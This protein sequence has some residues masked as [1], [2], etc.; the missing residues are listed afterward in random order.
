MSSKFKWIFVAAVFFKYCSGEIKETDQLCKYSLDTCLKNV[1]VVLN[2]TELNGIPKSKTDVDIV[3]KGFKIGMKCLDDYS[4]LCLTEDQK[5]TVSDHIIGAKYTFRFLCDD[6]KFQ[7]D[8]LKYTDCYRVIN[9]DWD[10]CT[11]RFMSLVREAMN[12]NLTE[13]IKVLDLCCYIYI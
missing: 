5:K 8:Y 1:S 4:K 3:C 9:T 10:D 13:D 12:S 7:K 2:N 11:N 6:Q